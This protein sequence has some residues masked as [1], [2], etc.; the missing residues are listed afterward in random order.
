LGID[1]RAAATAIGEVAFAAA[2]TPVVL[3]FPLDRGRVRQLRRGDDVPDASF[4]VT[5]NRWQGFRDA[6][7]R[8][9]RP[10]AA[11]RLA[12]CPVNH[13]TDGE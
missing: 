11:L 7:T 5:R 4:P 13:M 3:G 12:V 9:G 10:A 1:D 2:R 6:W 8:R